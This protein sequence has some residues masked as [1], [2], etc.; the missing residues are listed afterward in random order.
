MESV[1]NNIRERA[2]FNQ[3]VAANQAILLRLREED[4]TATD[5][6]NIDVEGRDTFETS[7]RK[8]HT[9]IRASNDHIEQLMRYLSKL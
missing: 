7:Q 4:T 6:R 5:L 2:R 9:Y 1:T 8:V 3:L